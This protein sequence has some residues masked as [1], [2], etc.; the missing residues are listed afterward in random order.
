MLRA[1]LSPSLKLWLDPLPEPSQL[2]TCPWY[3]ELG[4]PRLCTNPY[5]C[6]PGPVRGT[7]DLLYLA[8]R[9]GQEEEKQLFCPY[10][11]PGHR[12]DNVVRV[13]L[14]VTTKTRIH[15]HESCCNLPSLAHIVS[16]LSPLDATRAACTMDMS[17]LLCWA[18]VHMEVDWS[19][20]PYTRA[21]GT[22]GSFSLSQAASP[23]PARPAAKLSLTSLKNFPRWSRTSR[24]MLVAISVNLFFS[25]MR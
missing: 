14:Y 11:E 6:Q 12:I 7:E 22:R 8:L 13:R 19:C 2:P 24:G 23:C 4:Y 21:V 18:R 16:F 3:L 10:R 5:A 15:S 20:A 17:A 1:T 25:V 9:H